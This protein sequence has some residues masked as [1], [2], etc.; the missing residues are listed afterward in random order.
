MAFLLKAP[1]MQRDLKS[2]IEANQMQ[3]KPSEIDS[4]EAANQIIGESQ[5]SFRL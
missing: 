2:P 1:E 4:A 3:D 5:T